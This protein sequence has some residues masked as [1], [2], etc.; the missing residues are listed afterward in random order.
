[1]LLVKLLFG[2]I[3]AAFSPELK[4]VPRRPGQEAAAAWSGRFVIP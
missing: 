3:G 4:Q 1:M 2:R